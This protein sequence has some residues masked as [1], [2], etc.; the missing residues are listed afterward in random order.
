M[1][2]RSLS[3]VLYGIASLILT[4]SLSMYIKRVS[5]LG[6]GDVLITAIVF[7][8][9]LE[10]L[11]IPILF[12]EITVLL[13]GI[14]FRKNMRY[15]F[16]SA[17]LLSIAYF[18]FAV[19]VWYI[20][21]YPILYQQ[22]VEVLRTAIGILGFFVFLFGTAVMIHLKDTKV[23]TLGSVFI[24]LTAHPLILCLFGGFLQLAGALLIAIALWK[25]E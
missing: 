13:V 18:I 22:K 25:K 23:G 24:L 11:C 3:F 9:N 8:K 21:A 6:G 7:V 1:N 16:Y 17:L 5:I 2:K 10:V 4:L 14:T 12:S 15:V 20:S 19:V